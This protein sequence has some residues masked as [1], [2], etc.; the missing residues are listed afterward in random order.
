[1]AKEH[2]PP[3]MLKRHWDNIVGLSRKV[4]KKI[5]QS[6]KKERAA[7]ML[8][9]LERT[10]AEWL[11]VEQVTQTL[12]HEANLER[13]RHLEMVK[14]NLPTEH[15]LSPIPKEEIEDEIAKLKKKTEKIKTESLKEAAKRVENEWKK[16]KSDFF[17]LLRNSHDFPLINKVRSAF[18]SLTK[19]LIG[20]AEDEDL[21]VV[22]PWDLRTERQKQ[23]GTEEATPRPR[24]WP[25]M[26]AMPE[27]S[28]EVR[29]VDLIHSALREIHDS[30]Y[31]KSVVEAVA[32]KYGL[33]HNDV[34]WLSSVLAA[35]RL[36]KSEARKERKQLRDE[37]R[38]EKK[39]AEEWTEEDEVKFKEEE[40]KDSQEEA[41]EK[42][43]EK[44][45]EEEKKPETEEKDEEGSSK[46]EVVHPMKLYPGNHKKRAED[47]WDAILNKLPR[48]IHHYVKDFSIEYEQGSYDPVKK[49]FIGKEHRKTHLPETTDEPGVFITPHKV[50]YLPPSAAG[51][52]HR[53]MTRKLIKAAVDIFFRLSNVLVKKKLD[54]YINRLFIREDDIDHLVNGL[55]ALVEESPGDAQKVRREKILEDIEKQLKLYPNA[56][57]VQRFH[58][59]WAEQSEH[60]TS[61]FSDKRFIL[62]F[63]K[64]VLEVVTSM[65]MKSTTPKHVPFPIVD[66]IRK[67]SSLDRASQLLVEE[68]GKARMKLMRSPGTD[69]ALSALK[70]AVSRV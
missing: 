70:E 63:H 34:V 6:D 35:K 19:P 31:N 38:E 51:W 42:K 28:G 27:E 46:E 12:P 23:E 25:G 41:E 59:L 22:V 26:K 56:E 54:G 45:K 67:M 43:Q 20:T 57:K 7:S 10:F 53:T 37:E 1:M 33:P 32:A 55:N 47:S 24:N 13:L 3:T 40:E 14:K 60:F 11:F 58:E 36:S 44:T 16:E 66:F 68:V 18:E 15:A 50:I 48:A 52:S 8:N 17:K 64:W 39:R 4:I 2:K 30:R 29:L 61:M 65:V 69:E 5:P 9:S 62:L 21:A 49:T